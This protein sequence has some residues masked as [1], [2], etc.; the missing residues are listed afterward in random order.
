MERLKLS[1]FRSRIDMKKTLRSIGLSCI[2]GVIWP[3]MPLLGWS[4][5]SLE[6][7]LTSCSIEWSE[8]SFNVISYNITI[9]ICVFIIPVVALDC[10]ALRLFGGGGRCGPV[11]ACFEPL[12]MV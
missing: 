10:P 12:G 11:L 3:I 9:L 1:Y 4:H 2:L 7:N 6:G 8:K 5:Y